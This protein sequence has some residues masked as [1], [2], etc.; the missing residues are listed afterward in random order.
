MNTATTFEDVIFEDIVPPN[1][2]WAFTTRRVKK[3]DVA[4][5]STEFVTV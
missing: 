1:A 5:L 2:K 4:A 3:A